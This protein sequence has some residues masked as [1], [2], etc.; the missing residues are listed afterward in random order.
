M[1]FIKNLITENDNQTFCLIRIVAFLGALYFAA[2]SVKNF[3]YYG[4]HLGEWLDNFIKLMESYTAV[5]AK[6]FTE[7]AGGG[8]G[9]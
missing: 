5:V 7:K 1:N 3:G 2:H 9:N 8:N 6:A 4:E